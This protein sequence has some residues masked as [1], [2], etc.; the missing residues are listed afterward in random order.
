MGPIIEY[1]GLNV[2]PKFGVENLIHQNHMLIMFGGGGHQKV[3][4]IR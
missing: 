2:F 1:Y 3:I 4:M